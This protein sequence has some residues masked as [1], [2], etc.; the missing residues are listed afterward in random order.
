MQK[1]T[2]YR[3]VRPDGGASVSPIRPDAEHTELFRLVAGEGMVLTDGENQTTCID[4]DVPD[5][6]VE[7]EDTETSA[8]PD[9]AT[10]ADYQNAL[11]DMGVKV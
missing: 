9:E 10:E 8:D 4:T 7:V 2:L 6:W 1:I 3:Y 11:R 5:N